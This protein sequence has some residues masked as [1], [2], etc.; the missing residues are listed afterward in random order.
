MSELLAIRLEEY[1]KEFNDFKRMCGVNELNCIEEPQEPRKSRVNYFV[2]FVALVA[3]LASCG[4]TY[5][6]GIIKP[7]KEIRK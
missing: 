5:T 3:L 2:I 4:V 7:V 1:N 6:T